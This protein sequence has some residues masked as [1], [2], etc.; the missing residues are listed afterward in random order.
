M[1]TEYDDIIGLPHHRS[2]KR[3]PM[4]MHDRAAQFSPFAALTGFD[5]VIEETGRITDCRREL[6]DFGK[7]RL[8]RALLRLQELLPHRPR[9][10]MRCFNADPQKDGGTYRSCSGHVR[11]I[12]L[13]RQIIYLMDGTAV[14]MEDIFEMEC[15]EFAEE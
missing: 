10:T 11:K 2:K 4:S 8:D 7:E 12:D 15:E 1:N 13:Y 3:S 5:S 14:P 9:V 6:E